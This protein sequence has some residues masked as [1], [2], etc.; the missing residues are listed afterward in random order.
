MVLRE[1]RPAE[2]RVE[3]QRRGGFDGE[4]MLYRALRVKGILPGMKLQATYGPDLVFKMGVR[5]GASCVDHKLEHIRISF[6]K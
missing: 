5:N 6:L 4:K 1:K 2:L 3:S